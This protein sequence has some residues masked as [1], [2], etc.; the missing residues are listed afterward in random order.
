MIDGLTIVR[1]AFARTV[2]L[3]ST[4]RL[5]APVLADLVE[6]ADLDALAEIEGATSAR[7]TAEARGAPAIAANE[8]VH[9]VPHAHFINAAFAYARPDT[10]NRF[11]GPS[12]APGMQR[13]R[14]KP[15]WPKSPIT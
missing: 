10:L 2:R 7:R 12:A 3:V 4:A 14:S 8:L 6:D 15:A 13:S 5:R 9:G 1:D 11:N